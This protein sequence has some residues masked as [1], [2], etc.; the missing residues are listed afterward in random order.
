MPATPAHKTPEMNSGKAPTPGVSLTA[1]NPSARDDGNR[2]QKAQELI[3]PATLA[4]EILDMD[5]DKAPTQKTPLR[6]TAPCET[7]GMNSN[8]ESTKEEL[9]FTSPWSLSYAVKEIPIDAARLRRR[10]KQEHGGRRKFSDPCLRFGRCRCFFVPASDAESK[11]SA[12]SYVQE[13][14]TSSSD[15]IFP[16]PV[17]HPHRSGSLTW[18]AHVG[19]V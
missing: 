10:R 16:T 9:N 13:S 14:E 3:L 7:Q 11:Q 6:R 12:A 4:R 1:L 15:D 8:A 18:D 19:S 17:V 2:R 5:T